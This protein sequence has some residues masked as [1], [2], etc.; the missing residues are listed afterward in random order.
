MRR[1][2]LDELVGDL[3]E[4]IAET[5]DWDRVGA[6]KMAWEVVWHPPTILPRHFRF[7]KLN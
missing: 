1:R 7:A 5:W 2:C 3:R 4:V 6:Y